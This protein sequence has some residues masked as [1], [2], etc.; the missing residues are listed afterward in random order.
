M[1]VGERIR[2]RRIEL[3]LTQEELAHKLGYKSKAS[4]NKIELG[5]QDLPQKKI[6]EVAKALETTP[7]DLMGWNERGFIHVSEKEFQKVMNN[8]ITVVN[9]EIEH[10]QSIEEKIVDAYMK[11][12]EITQRHVRLLLGIDK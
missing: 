2:N 6:A 10:K 4:I 8:V 9:T 11:A 5:I 7:S 3:E 1:T 12:D